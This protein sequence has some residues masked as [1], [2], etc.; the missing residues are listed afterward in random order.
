[1]RLDWSSDVGAD[2][3]RQ[4]VGSWRDKA[5]LY[6]CKDATATAMC[7]LNAMNISTNTNKIHDSA[8]I[9]AGATPVGFRRRR[10]LGWLTPGVR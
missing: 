5:R 8:K 2:D 3:G 10:D 6:P 1:M 9:A 4:D 7:S